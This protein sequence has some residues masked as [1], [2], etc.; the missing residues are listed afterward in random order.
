MK[1][2]K[3]H[4]KFLL[5]S[6]F[7]FFYSVFYLY[8]KH[9]VG[10]DTSISEWL[11]NYSG[12]FTRRGLGGEINILFSNIFDIPLRV[13]IFFLQSILHLC[14]IILIF[15]YL[16]NFSLNI[17]QLF[18]LFSPLF[19]IYPIAEIE[20][21]GRKEI[22]LLISFIVSVYL[23]DKKFSAK[24]FNFQIFFTFPI[25]CLVW[26]Q[27]VLFAPFF[28]VLIIYK[29]N[30]KTFMDTTKYS[31]VIFAPSIITF[32]LIF[33]NPLSLE[34]HK[35][36]CDFLL[37]KFGERCYM[38]AVLLVHNT[39]Y[40]DT[41]HIHTSAKF[42]PDYF[43]YLLIFIVGFSFLHISLAKNNFSHR[44]N[45]I[46]AYFK[47]IYLFFLLYIPILPLFVFGLDW[48]RWI[49][50]TYSLSI[51]LYFYFLKNSFITNLFEIK[52]IFLKKIIQKRIV[53]YFLFFLFAFY[54]SPKTVITG[55]IA[56][57]TFYKIVYNSTKK[58][59]NHDGI[60]LFQDN[61]IIKFHKQYIE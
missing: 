25:L 2:I 3:I 54:W 27:V 7:I 56:T 52:N 21:L 47:P 58:I 50:I 32:F 35:L 49:H 20:A 53:L 6:C 17:F 44:K 60:R 34:G 4:N 51:I 16:K 24:I 45:L 10:N 19:L 5:F 18:A 13:S 42:F 12:G 31:L 43:R 1:K 46:S 11:I 40:F 14:F 37:N 36:M 15:F 55:D 22:L 9:N 29:N 41:L 23:A 26:E 57:N 28:V 30:L 59:F 38:S 8:F 61:P 39:I 33:N 48:G